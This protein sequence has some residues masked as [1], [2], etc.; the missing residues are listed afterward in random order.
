VC[1]SVKGATAATAADKVIVL[2]SILFFAVVVFIEEM[3]SEKE[4]Q[5]A[6][7]E[8]LFNARKSNNFL[9]LL[10]GRPGRGIVSIGAFVEILV[11]SFYVASVR[12]TSYDLCVINVNHFGASNVDSTSFPRTGFVVQAKRLSVTNRWT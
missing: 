11:Q 8:N 9:N 12:V 2:C 1:V 4:F 7:L 10:T 3:K 5:M 6:P